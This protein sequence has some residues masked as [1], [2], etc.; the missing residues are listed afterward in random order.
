MFSE[1]NIILS[2]FLESG[3]TTVSKFSEKENKKNFYFGYFIWMLNIMLGMQTY[4]NEYSNTNIN[5]ILIFQGR[6]ESG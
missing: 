5:A 4:S 2:I 1:K 3:K 6:E